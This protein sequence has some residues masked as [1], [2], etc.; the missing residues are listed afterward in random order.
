MDKK[1]IKRDLPVQLTTEEIMEKAKELAKL[2]Q[3]KIACEDQAKSAAATFKDRIAAAVANINILSRDISNGYEYRP[4]ECEWTYDWTAGQKTLVR[5]DT[6]ETVKTE[7]ITHEER[8][9]RIDEAA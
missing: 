9:S 4:I 5:R 3:D 1:I 2:Q 6:W 7:N 8:Q